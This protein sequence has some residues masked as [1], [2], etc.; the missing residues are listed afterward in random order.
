MKIKLK[1]KTFNYRFSNEKDID[2]I[3]NF[4]KNI[5]QNVDKK[6]YNRHNKENILKNL[7]RGKLFLVFYNEK[8]IS[9]AGIILETDPKYCSYYNLS[10]KEMKKSGC[11]IA[12]AVSKRYRGYGIQKFLIEKRIEYLKKINRKYALICVHPDNKI[13]MKNILKNNFKFIKKAKDI[14]NEI[15]NYYLLKI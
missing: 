8:L 11:L 12:T 9:W 2:I 14:N 7:K 5:Y 1:E 15:N 3:N 13:S 6:I 4:D 10:E